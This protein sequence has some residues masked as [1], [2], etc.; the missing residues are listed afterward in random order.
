MIAR[1]ERWL[2]ARRIAAANR[3]LNR[4]IARNLAARSASQQVRGWQTRRAGQ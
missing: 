4:L 3:E 1:I 2:R